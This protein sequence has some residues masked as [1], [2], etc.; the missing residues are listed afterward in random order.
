MNLTLFALSASSTLSFI[1]SQKPQ[2]ARGGAHL[3]CHSRFPPIHVCFP[4]CPSQ[5]LPRLPAPL[6]KI[7]SAH[8]HI[9]GKKWQFPLISF[10]RLT[11]NGPVWLYLHKIL[12][13]LEQNP[14][15]LA[16]MLALMG[17]L[18]PR[19]CLMMSKRKDKSVWK[20]CTSSKQ[21]QM[22]FKTF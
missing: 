1:S 9:S 18:V 13:A 5:L 20:S 4:S 2:H 17:M 8:M 7:M 21:E 15:G 10:S 12:F 16:L 22:F 3:L 6:L 11:L 14:Y 19:W